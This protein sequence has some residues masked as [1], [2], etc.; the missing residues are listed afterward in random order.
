M[1]K[2][3]Q[4]LARGAGDILKEGFRK[5]VKTSQKSA[6]WDVVT[7]YDKRSEKFIIDHI[8]KKFPRHGILGEESGQIG[9][10]KELW[11]IDPLDGTLTFSKGLSGF[12]VLIAHLINGKLK[13]GVIYDPIQNDLFCATKGKGAFLNNKK[14]QVGGKSDLLHALGGGW[15]GFRDSTKIERESVYN[16][17]LKNNM[18]WAY[19]TGVGQGHVASGTFDFYADVEGMPWDYAPG[20]LIAEE[21]GCKIS[22]INGKPFHLPLIAASKSIL[23]A[24]P[25][26]HKLLVK[27]LK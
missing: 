27:E 2:F 5:N 17:L 19:S 24:N 10:K 25:K 22:E 9:G 16:V 12:C 6:S 7:E 21:A 11:I 3:I 8:Q 18:M 4:N 13:Y 23:I 26:L 15:L 1:E 14:I 20:I